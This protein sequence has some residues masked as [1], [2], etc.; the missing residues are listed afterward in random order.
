MACS[1]ERT[2]RVPP[3]GMTADPVY[4][5]EELAAIARDREQ[6]AA[7]KAARARRKDVAHRRWTM[8]NGFVDEAVPHAE[9]SD[10]VLW[11]LMFRHARA[12]G[13]VALSRSRLE[14]ATRLNRKTITAALA[15][16]V[17]AGWLQRMRRGGPSGGMAV[18]CVKNNKEGG[19][20]NGQR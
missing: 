4:S 10:V 16:L 5:P 20:I 8:L 13:I 11:L 2:Y 14:A 3:P 9:M 12:D 6:R 7:V 15:R 17:S 18:Y 19:V 1:E